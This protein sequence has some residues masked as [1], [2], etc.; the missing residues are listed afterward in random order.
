MIGRIIAIA[1]NTFREAI[2]NKVL[3]GIVAAVIGMNL[4]AVVLGAMSLA[5]EAR[6]AR[7]VGLAGVSLFG[8][9]TAIFLGVSLL[10]A[11]IQKRTIHVILAKPIHRH[12]FVL[13]K[14]AGMAVTLTLLVVAF[15]VALA[16]MLTL[17][18]FSFDENVVKAVTLGW[19]EVMLVAAIAIFFSS[20][21]TPFLSG[22]FTFAIFFIGRS[23]KEL[24]YAAA[25]AKDPLLQNIGKAALYVIPDLHLFSVS[26]GEVDGKAVSV[27]ANFVSWLYVGHA[28]LYALAVVAILLILAVVVFSRRDFA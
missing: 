17:S 6:I 4:F 5:E 13:G 27:H 19:L 23:S 24:E 1:L 14:Y 16:L 12:E 10:Y 28:A 3:Y 22:I 2:R 21:S 20:F 15:A 11:E 7:D 9:I 26:G 25:K 18:G 8:A